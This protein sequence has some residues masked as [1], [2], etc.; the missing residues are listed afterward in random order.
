MSGLFG[1]LN[2]A[3]KGLQAAQ[4]ALH[5]AGHNISNANTDGFSRQRVELKASLAYTL[6]GV[7]QLG[8][9]VKMESI[10]RVVDDYVTKQI[11]QENGTMKQ[12]AVKSEVMDQLEIIYNE[13]SETGLNFNLGEMF[14]AWTEL[15][16]NPEMLTA[17]SIVV[18]KSKTMAD[19]LNHIAKQLEGLKTNTTDLIEMNAKDFNS[20][21]DKLDS[22]NTQIFNIGIKGQTP[23]DLLDQRDLLLRDLSTITNFSTDFD[24]YGRVQIG[25]DTGSSEDTTVLSFNGSTKIEMTADDNGIIILEGGIAFSPESGEIAGYQDALSDIN[26]QMTK[27]DKF[28]QTMA[29]AINAA[30]KDGGAFTGDFFTF[31]NGEFKASNIQVNSA[32]DSDNSLVNA[33]K[34]P[35]PAEGDGSKAQDVANVRN[36]KLD[37]TGDGNT[38]NTIESEYNSMV[39]NVGISKQQADN[40]VANQEVLLDQLVMRRESTSGVQIDEEVSNIIKFQ[41][42]YEANARVIQVLSEMLDVLINRTGV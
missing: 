34:G 25:L 8:T 42:S 14:D 38:D 12:F 35:N 22:L 28:A 6:G 3:N 41:K 40:M 27:L 4:T 23:N 5:T 31:A 26:E 37:F 20:I 17:K 9:G 15:S 30:H 24:K 7:G 16:K 10:I 2:V 1:T 36:I 29:E 33:G 13:P 19:T 11:R 18:E 39:T 32:I 21:I